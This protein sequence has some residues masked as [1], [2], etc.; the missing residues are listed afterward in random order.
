MHHDNHEAVEAEEASAHAV[1]V[2]VKVWD[3]HLHLH[4]NVHRYCFR[5][6][7]LKSESI[8]VTSKN[9]PQ[10]GFEPGTYGILFTWIWDS[11][12][13]HSATTAGF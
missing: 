8:L 10:A 5:G 12:S 9:M 3:V 13:D 2:R 1:K 6:Q 7:T 11:A 4:L